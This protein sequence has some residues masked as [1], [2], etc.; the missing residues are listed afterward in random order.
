MTTTPGVETPA[1]TGA[2]PSPAVPLPPAFV[3]GQENNHGL[4][5]LILQKEKELHD[6]NERR[7]RVRRA[8]DG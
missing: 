8:A 2:D 1:A 5:G 3:T 4:R 6:I 7:S